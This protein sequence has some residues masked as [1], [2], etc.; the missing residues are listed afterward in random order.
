MKPVVAFFPAGIDACALVRMY[1]PHLNLPGS[2]FLFS[3]YANGIPLQQ[4]EHCNI[5][6]VQRLCSK[7][8]FETIKMFKK[9]GIKIV[10]DLDD[11]MWSVPS[12]NPVYPYMKQI[13][14]GFRICGVHADVITVSTQHLKV[15]VQENIGKNCPKVEVVENALD[16]DWFKPLKEEYRKDKK[17]RVIVGWAGTD[18]HSEDIAKVF[19]LI[20]E[21]LRELPEMNFEVAG[22]APPDWFAEFG[23]R[24]RQRDFV[25]ISEYPSYLASYQWDL[26]LAPLSNH[27]FNKSK[28][29]LKQIEAATSKIPC[30]GSKIAPYSNFCGHSPLLKK[31]ALAESPQEWKEKIRAL[32]KDSSYREQVGQEMYRVGMEHYNI[33]GRMTRWNDVFES[34]L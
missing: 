11:D 14:P 29:A 3:Y 7:E 1:L 31:A 4:F 6:V 22:I 10:Y 30:I 23:D 2:E 19:N 34:I 33:K 8:N 12:Y 32:V 25:P 26:S 9:L 24:V 28:S 13:L 18:T 15:M 27:R 20:P 17:G 21:L 16:F 5:A